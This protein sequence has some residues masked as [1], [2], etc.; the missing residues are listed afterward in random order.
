MLHYGKES[1]LRLRTPR[2]RPAAIRENGDGAAPSGLRQRPLGAAAAGVT[3]GET[4]NARTYRARI[5]PEVPVLS[6][7]LTVV[8]RD[9]VRLRVESL[10]D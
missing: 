10:E 1:V 4:R 9:R 6:G 3:D 2:W 5:V 7:D 8:A